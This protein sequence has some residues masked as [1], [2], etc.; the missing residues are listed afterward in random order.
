MLNWR[1]D[2]TAARQIV[3]SVFEATP[4][5]AKESYCKFLAASI[6]YLSR[7]WP[8]R[9]G[10]TLYKNGV[11]LNASWVE[12]LVLHPGGLRVLVDKKAAP[13]HT[14]FDGRTYRY[15]PGCETAAIPLS[16][17]SRSLPRLIGSHHKALAIAASQRPAHRNI[18]SGHSTGVTRWLSQVLRRN[19]SNPATPQRPLHIVQGGIQNGDKARLE[20]LA[21]SGRRTHSWVAPKTVATGD[22]IVVY[23]GGFG[24][25]AT[26]RA[27]SEAK[28]RAGW[29]N[30]YGAGLN[31]IA[32][33]DP[34]ISLAAIRRHIPDLEWAKYLAASRPHRLRHQTKFGG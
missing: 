8:A 27:E 10:V 1:S 9:W 21:L 32:L 18:L 3:E 33:I 4:A 2:P 14:N 29:K 15:A 11:R 34:P 26:A 20:R 24:F 12:S 16:E 5:S 7:H 17:L 28:P 31:S 30:R 13:P 23:I 25:F 22:E 19:V 6:R